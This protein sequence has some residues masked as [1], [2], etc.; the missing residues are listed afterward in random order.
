MDVIEGK[1][2]LE[3]NVQLWKDTSDS[4]SQ[5]WTKFYLST[6]WLLP[7]AKIGLTE[8]FT[9]LDGIEQALFHLIAKAARMTF[10]ANLMALK[11]DCRHLG[12]HSVQS[13]WNVSGRCIF[14]FLFPLFYK[15]KC[16]W[17]GLLELLSKLKITDLRIECY[18]FFW[19]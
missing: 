13:Q 14:V 2:E 6:V 9:A 16:T 17:M 3:P 11:L 12:L 4:Y 5:S 18:V 15:K 19:V 8:I 10:C 1:P 7:V